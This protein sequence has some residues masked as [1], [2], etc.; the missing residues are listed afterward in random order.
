M[1]KSI[2]ATLILTTV[3][4]CS[5]V[6]YAKVGV[7]YKLEEQKLHWCNNNKGCR[8]GNKPLSARFEVGF[9]I[10]NISYGI[11]HDSQYGQGAPFNNDEEYFKTEI[12]IDYKWGGK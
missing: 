10:D 12:F 3:T 1:R 2:L 11:S 7:G 8:E 9:E 5:S 6:P 4:G